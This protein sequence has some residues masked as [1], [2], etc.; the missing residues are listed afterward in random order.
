VNGS[1]LTELT[2]SPFALPAGAT[3]A[4]IAVR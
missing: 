3:P 2:S 4:G 1:S